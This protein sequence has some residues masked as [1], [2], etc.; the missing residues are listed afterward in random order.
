MERRPR[1]AD[2]H[3][4]GRPRAGRCKTDATRGVGSGT[5]RG[6]QLDGRPL[7]ELDDVSR[8]YRSG[9]T[10]L[11]ALDHVSLRVDAGE[12][13][14]IMGTS[15]SGKSTMM[16]LIGLLDRPNTGVVK[17]EGQPVS[18]LGDRAL[19]RIRNQKIGFVFQSFHLLPRLSALEN[20]EVPLVYA[21]VGT[22]ERR[23]RSRK[24]L[25]E[26]GLGDRVGHRPNQLSGGQ[27]QRVAIARA[28]VNRPPLLLADEPTGALDTETTRQIMN[29]IGGLHES[30]LTILIVT[31]EPHVARYAKRVVWMRDGH[32]VEDGD[33]DTVLRRSA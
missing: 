15:G 2:R 7:V 5:E 9:D 33:P 8:I 26:V 6:G 3:Q 28:L 17:L 20:V 23:E 25:E 18:K 21:G 13:V 22:R 16:N 32:I 14:A 27:Q 19:S 31:H 12:Y 10:E 11:R 30:G 29:L 24:A 1:V 4:R